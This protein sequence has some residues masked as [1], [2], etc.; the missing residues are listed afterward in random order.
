MWGKIE[1]SNG[2]QNMGISNPLGN[3]YSAG[4]AGN[5]AK[6]M[7]NIEHIPVLHTHI[8][9]EDLFVCL[10]QRQIYEGYFIN[11]GSL[12][13]KKIR[14]NRNKK[15]KCYNPRHG[16]SSQINMAEKKSSYLF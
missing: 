15:T 14:G 8:A 12:P 3:S 5:D 13:A 4:S 2:C 9:D 6:Q 10:R 16:C 11:L 7:K 1:T